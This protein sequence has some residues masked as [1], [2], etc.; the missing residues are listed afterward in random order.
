MK[1]LHCPASS[2]INFLIKHPQSPAQ[3][4]VF[5]TLEQKTLIFTSKGFKQQNASIT[6]KII[7]CSK[8]HSNLRFQSQNTVLVTQMIPISNNFLPHFAIFNNYSM[9]SNTVIHG[10]VFI[11]LHLDF[12][13]KFYYKGRMGINCQ[14]QF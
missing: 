13:A 9:K 5:F 4:T 1:T 7:T 8:L 11:V 10:K 12:R 2:N 3:N 6:R 14:I